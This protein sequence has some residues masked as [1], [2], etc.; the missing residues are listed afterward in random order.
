MNNLHIQTFLIIEF[1]I[2]VIAIIGA[3]LFAEVLR[4][5]EDRLACKLRLIKQEQMSEEKV[6]VEDYMA[7]IHT[8]N[9]ILL[10]RVLVYTKIVIFIAFLFTIDIIAF[11]HDLTGLKRMFLGIIL[12][13]IFLTINYTFSKLAD[14]FFKDKKYNTGGNG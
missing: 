5:K 2:I 8:N 1:I 10:L 11:N 7:T 14:R 12:A 4:R 6:S 3:F 9:A 13:I